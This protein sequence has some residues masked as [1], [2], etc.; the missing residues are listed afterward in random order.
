MRYRNGLP[1]VISRQLVHMQLNDF[2]G[3]KSSDE[4]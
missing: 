2:Y 3:G 1:F 4:T